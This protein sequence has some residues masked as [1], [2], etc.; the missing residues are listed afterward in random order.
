MPNKRNASVKLN[1]NLKNFNLIPNKSINELFLNQIRSDSQT[2]KSIKQR[3]K[4]I[5]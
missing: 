5:A 4:S 1:S 2:M 3:S